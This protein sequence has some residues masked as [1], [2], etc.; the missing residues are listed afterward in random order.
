MDIGLRW[1]GELTPL[2]R[3]T[4]LELQKYTRQTWPDWATDDVLVE[5]KKPGRRK[6]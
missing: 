1:T 6:A 2:L 3:D 5:P 4:I